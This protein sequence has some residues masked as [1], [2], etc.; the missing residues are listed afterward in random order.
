MIQNFP[1]IAVMGIYTELTSSDIENFRLISSLWKTFN[2]QLRQAGYS[3]G[4]N[5]Q[6]FGITA[7]KN[8]RYFYYTAVPRSSVQTPFREFKIPVFHCLLFTNTGAMNKLSTTISNIYAQ[9][10]PQMG[11]EVNLNRRIL[12]IERYANKF[13]WNADDSVIEIFVPVEI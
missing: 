6:K 13:K 4:T 7:Q 1:A 2:S 12:H 5:W 11:I 9:Q 10:L 3:S 8:G